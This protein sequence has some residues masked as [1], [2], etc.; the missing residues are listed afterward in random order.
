VSLLHTSAQVWIQTMIADVGPGRFGQ[1]NQ[2]PGWSRTTRPLSN[3]ASVNGPRTSG[4]LRW[5][6][7]RRRLISAHVRSI[8][9]DRRFRAAVVACIPDCLDL[10]AITHRN[11]PVGRHSQSEIVVTRTTPHA[12]AK[13]LIECQLPGHDQPALGFLGD[14][15]KPRAARPTPRQ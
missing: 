6:Q 11:A 2:K 5:T 7:R 13:G 12:L 8:D 4:E 1:T 9:R 14:T 3:C 10:H 15:V